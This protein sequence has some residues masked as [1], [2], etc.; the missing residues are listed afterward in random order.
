VII[1]VDMDS[2]LNDFTTGYVAYYNKL[3]NKDVALEN[4]DLLRYE[5]SK[6]LPG[7]SDKEAFEI[8]ENIFSTNGF[9]KDIPIMKN[10]VNIMKELYDNYNVYIVTAPWKSSLN[11]YNEKIE[12][13][14][15]HMPWFDLDKVIY[16]RDKHLLRGDIIIDDNPHYITNHRCDWAIAPRYPF[17]INL[18]AFYFNEWKEV[19]G[20][21]KEIKYVK[22]K[23]GG[24][25]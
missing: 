9:W 21:V 20:I 24:Q 18:P 16:C 11:C 15:K 23:Y 7:V 3:Y 1:F 25:I 12:W 4:K 8:R 17:N 14:A 19:P 22:T 10:A 5:I 6:A 13:I 2:T